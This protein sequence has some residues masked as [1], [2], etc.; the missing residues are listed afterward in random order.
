MSTIIIPE[1]FFSRMEGTI[2]PKKQV[3]RNFIDLTVGKIFRLKSEGSL[4]FGGSEYSP[5]STE[6]CSPV[7]N[8]VDDSYGWWNLHEGYF[9]LGYNEHFSLQ[10]NE[11]AVIQPHPHLLHAGCFHSTLF[12]KKLEAD[13]RVL[14]WVPKLGLNLKENARISQLMVFSL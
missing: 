1:S 13:F 6:P 5:A 12:L 2:S 14:I 11:V 8:D 7:K 4:D 9:L 10:D 3:Y